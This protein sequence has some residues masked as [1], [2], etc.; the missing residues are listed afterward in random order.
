MTV[1][2]NANHSMLALLSMIFGILIASMATAQTQ[3]WELLNGTSNQNVANVVVTRP[4]NIFGGFNFGR[5]FRSLDGGESWTKVWDSTMNTFVHA[6][7][8]DSSGNIY[9]ATSTLEIV[10]DE[11]A[12]YVGRIIRSSDEGTTWQSAD[13][14][15]ERIVM[16]D[17]LVDG[18]NRLYAGTYG[19]KVFRSTDLGMSW[20][21]IRDDHSEAYVHCLGLDQHGNIWTGDSRGHLMQSR[22]SGSTWSDI[23]NIGKSIE[24][25]APGNGD[26]VYAGAWDDFHVDGGVYGISCE[27][28]TWWKIGLQSTSVVS[29]LQHDTLLLAGTTGA[30]VFSLARSETTWIPYSNGLSNLNVW[31]LTHGPRGELI[32]GTWG[33]LFRSSSSI[34]GTS[35]PPGAR[36]TTNLLDQNYPNPFNPSTTIAYHLP[37]RTHLR[38]AVFNVLGQQVDVLQNGECDAGS[39]TVRFDAAGLPSGIYFFRLNAGVFTE[40]RKCTLVR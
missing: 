30:G 6:F 20:L 9:A 4:G 24:S 15:I 33:G 27:S 34:L 8:V 39:H 16:N 12:Y 22:D 19:G 10:T 32:A 14:G 35:E 26:T 1:S 23:V 17:L 13:T 2:R 11:N 7:A 40:T 36:P 5:I 25:L 29:L 21:L 31:A 3:S 28:K 38:L 37:V 18:K